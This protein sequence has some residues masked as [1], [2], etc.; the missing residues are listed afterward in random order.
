MIPDIMY[1]TIMT[2]YKLTLMV[3]L[4]HCRQDN[5]TGRISCLNIVDNVNGFCQ[6][7]RR[8]SDYT[9]ARGGSEG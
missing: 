7:T 6:R 4:L 5:A 9:D 8:P 2:M 1:L 3:N